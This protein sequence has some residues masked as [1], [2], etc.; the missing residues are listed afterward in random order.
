MIKKTIYILL[1]IC[2]VVA[3]VFAAINRPNTHTLL[4]IKAEKSVEVEI[5]EPDSLTIEPDS[6]E[7]ST[8]EPLQ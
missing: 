4:P 3:V 8:V 2:A 6:V 5:T 7:L 1:H